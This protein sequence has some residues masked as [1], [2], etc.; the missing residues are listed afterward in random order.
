VAKMMGK[1]PLSE[2]TPA[3]AAKI[4]LYTS[5]YCG[6]AWLVENF[7][8]GSGIPAVIYNI[9]EDLE[10]R[11][12]LLY[13]NDGRGN[14]PTIIFP[15]GTKMIEPPLRVVQGSSGDGLMTGGRRQL[16]GGG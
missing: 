13:V 16:R 8:R 1:R 2:Q 10:A 4:I 7:I 9:D 14:V 12:D 5:N 6:H 11:D 15:D 3:A